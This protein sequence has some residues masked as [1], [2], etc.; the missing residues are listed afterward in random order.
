MK[1][2]LAYAALALIATPAAAVLRGSNDIDVDAVQ[3]QLS[4]M[5]SQAND[6]L[7]KAEK[8]HQQVV[9][10]TRNDIL[11]DFDSTAGGL[12]SVVTDFEASLIS[13]ES[14]MEA[15]IN[16][17]KAGIAQAA[18][19]PGAG[20]WEGPAFTQKAK[21]NAQISAAE[22]YLR[23]LKRGR[24]SQVH[25]A[26]GR[27]EEPLEDEEQRL[28]L[29]VGDLSKDMDAAKEKIEDTLDLLETS[30][31][32]TRDAVKALP[33]MKTMSLAKTPKEEQGQL[34]L[35]AK[36]LQAAMKES[37]AAVDKAKKTMDAA[38]AKASKAQ[39][40]KAAKIATDVRNS[41]KEDVGSVGKVKMPAQLLKK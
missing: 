14:R 19:A 32:M 6:R 4:T 24:V 40:A 8:H 23:K 5:M 17:S 21:L 7:A 1:L 30:G 41:Q 22:R 2:A 12:A 16:A 26:Q 27:A 9:D 11:E 34:E 29:V 20:D 13:V 33:A 10:D 38:L 36:N 35:L 3:Q 18:K 39:A 37:A 25:S 31:N 28:G 15:Q